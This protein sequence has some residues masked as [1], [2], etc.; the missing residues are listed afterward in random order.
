LRLGTSAAQSRKSV[1]FIDLRDRYGLTQ[2]VFIPKDSPQAHETANKLGNEF[3]ILVKGKVNPRPKGT[4]NPNLPTGLVELDATSVE[5]LNPSE[6]PVFEIDDNLDVSEELKL[7]YRYLDLRRP[8]ML[9]GLLLRHQICKLSEFLE[10]QNFVEI[11]TPIFNQ[12]Y[13][14]KARGIF[15]FHLGLIRASSLLFRN[16]RNYSNRF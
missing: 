2:V 13:P 16:R 12:I 9:K 15:W 11:E 5:I 14:G 6:V 4:E 1:F 7:A 10:Q 8:S 3:V